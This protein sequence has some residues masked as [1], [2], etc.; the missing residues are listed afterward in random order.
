LLATVNPSFEKTVPQGWKSS[1][2]Y[3]ATQYADCTTR[4]AGV[5][6]FHLS[7]TNVNKTIS[8]TT[9][10]KSTSASEGAK[11]N[12]VYAS[13]WVK[14]SSLPASGGTYKMA[15][16]LYYTDG[17]KLV[18]SCLLPRTPATYDWQKIT[19]VSTSTKAFSKVMIRLYAYLASGEV[20]FDDL[21]AAIYKP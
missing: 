8:Y 18:T 4:H 14:A 11:G 9:K 15:I 13:L 20:W 12:K 16:T 10:V 6:S 1:S 7:G 3:D 21:N 5:C 19:C 2:A 17:T